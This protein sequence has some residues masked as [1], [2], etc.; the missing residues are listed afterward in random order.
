MNDNTFD[1]NLGRVM[2]QLPE[3]P[4]A[5]PEFEKALLECTRRVAL[6]KRRR[7]W[8]SLAAAA[9]L[10]IGAGLVIFLLTSPRFSACSWGIHEEYPL[11]RDAAT[12]PDFSRRASLFG[13]VDEEESELLYLNPIRYLHSHGVDTSVSGLMAFYAALAR[14][15]ATQVDEP[16]Y[17]CLD[18]IFYRL[19]T[20][21]TPLLIQLHALDPSPS[22][23]RQVLAAIRRTRDDTALPYL[24]STVAHCPADGLPE[25]AQTLASFEVRDESAVRPLRARAVELRLLDAGAEGFSP[26]T[27]AKLLHSLAALGDTDAKRDAARLLAAAPHIGLLEICPEHVESRT[28]LIEKALAGEPSFGHT[29]LLAVL[30]R[31]NDPRAA[32]LLEFL[33]MDDDLALFGDTARVAGRHATPALRPVL[34]AALARLHEKAGDQRAALLWALARGGDKSAMAKIRGIVAAT[35]DPLAFEWGVDALLDLKANEAEVLNAFPDRRWVLGRLVRLLEWNHG[36]VMRAAPAKIATLKRGDLK[37]ALELALDPGWDWLPNTPVRDYLGY[38]AEYGGTNRRY[39]RRPELSRI[40]AMLADTGGE[41]GARLAALYALRLIPGA[42]VAKVEIARKVL[43]DVSENSV[44]FRGTAVRLLDELGTRE[45]VELLAKHA[46]SEPDPVIRTAALWAIAHRPTTEEIYSRIASDDL[47]AQT[48]LLEGI[49]RFARTSQQQ[50]ILA[51]AFERGSTEVR[52]VAAFQIAQHR[53]SGHREAVARLL[54]EAAGPD[55][56]AALAAEECLLTLR[57]AALIEVW[58]REL[59][60]PDPVRRLTAAGRLRVF[61]KQVFGVDAAGWEQWWAANREEFVLVGESR[62]IRRERR[63]TAPLFELEEE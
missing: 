42:A 47:L 45:A 33:L 48:I 25:L 41:F 60:S 19:G 14:G 10:L 39:L 34:E 5:S 3:V 12:R 61:T 22:G 58:I 30:C 56:V 27:A 35:S 1:R 6:G 4:A 52:R 40:Q 37:L 17:A 20:R 43:A 36:D 63:G 53:L 24:L 55:R 26:D 13:G 32:E 54:A 62:E 44:P 46:A 11:A 59:R 16:R 15:E 2:K 28:A 29:R 38:C 50:A 23:R 7:L 49:G 31:A 51:D 21:A 57:Q 9:V 8:I 18:A